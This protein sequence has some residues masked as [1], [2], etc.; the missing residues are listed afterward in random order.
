MPFL[1]AC[2]VCGYWIIWSVFPP[3][4]FWTLIFAAWFLGLSVIRSYG[5][6]EIPGAMRLRGALPVLGITALVSTI[7]GGPFVALWLPL[8]CLAGVAGL[9]RPRIWQ[10]ARPWARPAARWLS[11]TAVL[12]LAATAVV[13][14]R[15]ADRLTPAQRVLMTES[16]PVAGAELR[17]I[18]ECAPLQ[19]VIRGA[20]RDRQLVE[21]AVR[22]ARE[23][24]EPASLDRFWVAEIARTRQAG[25]ER[26]WKAEVLE[27]ERRAR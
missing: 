13:E 9:F 22:K 11:V 26:E 19:E 27:R 1:L 14:Y 2:G 10:P 18:T 12:T 24:C 16:T 25:E 20:V 23:I 8:V 6:A 5:Q 17:K 15:Q 21:K 3:S 4:T 7:A